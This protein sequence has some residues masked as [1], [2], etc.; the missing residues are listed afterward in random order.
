MSERRPTRVACNGEVST[1]NAR[2]TASSIVE[3][4]NRQ[5]MLVGAT[6]ID[7]RARTQHWGDL[8]HLVNGRWPMLSPEA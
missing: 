5:P 1:R 4:L 8:S 6:Q 2:K 3:E 7:T